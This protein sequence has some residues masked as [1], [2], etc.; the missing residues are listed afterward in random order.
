MRALTVLLLIGLSVA[1][2]Q[3]TPEEPS[4]ESA[5]RRMLTPAQADVFLVSGWDEKELA[6]IRRC[7]CPGCVKTDCGEGS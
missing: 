1:S 7:F 6:Q 5:V 2:C 3:T 4:A